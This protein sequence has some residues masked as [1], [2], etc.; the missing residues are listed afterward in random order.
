MRRVF[1]CNGMYT[2]CLYGTV[3][4]YQASYKVFH[5]ITTDGCLRVT[6]HRVCR[7]GTLA[8]AV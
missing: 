5:S 4:V 6:T 8:G 1:N 2:R 7:R 3:S